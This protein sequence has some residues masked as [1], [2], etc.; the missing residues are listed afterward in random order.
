MMGSVKTHSILLASL[1]CLALI[2]SATGQNAEV[3][4]PDE[5]ASAPKMTSGTKSPYP[6]FGGPQTGETSAETL[7]TFGMP[8]SEEP[9]T[10]SDATGAPDT[11]QSARGIA[12]GSVSS[13]E[14]AKSAPTPDVRYGNPNTLD[15]SNNPAGVETNPYATYDPSKAPAQSPGIQRGVQGNYSTAP[16]V[17][18]PNEPYRDPNAGKNPGIDGTDPYLD[19]RF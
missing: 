1:I 6:T 7:P 10:G 14:A 16:N 19:P 13:F 17:N 12:G 8:R 15:S 5:S 3:S 18:A 11:A 4:E 2:G 9:V